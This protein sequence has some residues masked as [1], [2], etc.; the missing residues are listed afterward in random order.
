MDSATEKLLHEG[1]VIPAH[2]LALNK[3]LQLDEKRQRRLTRYYIASGVGGLAVGVH[4]T[5]FS[6]RKPEIQLLEP[7][8]PG[9]GRNKTSRVRQTFFKGSRYLWT[10]SASDRGSQ[11]SG[12]IWLR[13]RTG[14]PWGIKG[15]FGRATD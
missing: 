15:F 3:D 1:T 9:C 10:Y 5:Q 11:L 7:A 14:E 13:P 2:P 8:S 12:K 6:I 4:T